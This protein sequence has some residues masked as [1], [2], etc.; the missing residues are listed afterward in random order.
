[1]YDVKNYRIKLLQMARPDFMLPSDTWDTEIS[2]ASIFVSLKHWKMGKIGIIFSLRLM[3]SH[4]WSLIFDRIVS[5]IP[6]AGRHILKA[7]RKYFGTGRLP[8]STK[9]T[10][11]S[12]VIYL[13]RL[14]ITMKRVPGRQTS[15]GFDV[16]LHWLSQK[17]Q[18][19]S[20]LMFVK[21]LL[22]TMS[23]RVLLRTSLG[24]LLPVKPLRQNIQI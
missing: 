8:R 21:T 12:N 11:S 6:P 2:S 14:I 13:L 18:K 23:S 10:W 20:W 7:E 24:I 9:S 1:M 4:I 22:L 16:C 17:S 15:D 5:H 3:G 19:V